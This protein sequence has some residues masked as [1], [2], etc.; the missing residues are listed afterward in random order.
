MRSDRI[1]GAACVAAAAAMGWAARGY[2]APIAYEPVGP[3]AFPM[4]LAVLIA[5]AGAWLV[6]K[7]SDHSASVAEG[8]FGALAGCIVTI[9]VYALMFESLGFAVATTLMAVP[10]GIAFGGNWRNSLIGGIGLGVG[11][12]LLFDRLLDVTLPMGVLAPLLKGL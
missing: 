6:I 12:Y 3:R 1:L 4:L 11:F 2:V 8:R 5:L 7:P 10:V 9:L